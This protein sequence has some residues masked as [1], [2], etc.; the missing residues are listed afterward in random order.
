MTR[1]SDRAFLLLL[2]IAAAAVLA[3]ADSGLP[4]MEEDLDGIESVVGG[5]LGKKQREFDYFALS[6]QWPGTMCNGIKKCCTKNGCCRGADTP[7]VFTIHGLWTDYNDGSWPECCDGPSFDPNE[8]APLQS[9]LDRYWP[10]YSCSKTSNCHGGK[11]TFWGHEW[12]KHGTC[13]NPVIHDE[14]NYFLITLNLYFNY[15]VTKVLNEEGYVPSNSERYPLG[16]II[17]AIENAFHLTPAVECTKDSIKEIHLC[18]YK[19][20]KPRDCVLQT[21]KMVT[22]S[23][24]CPE[25]VSL[26]EI[27]SLENGNDVLESLEL[28]AAL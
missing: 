5:G 12:E 6:L 17:A 16:G 27:E 19:D 7:Q 14:Y 24:S 2:L 28:D 22:S 8:V 3:T 10:S 18:F 1:S 25:Y 15:N 26:P 20:F 23:A 9:A 13:A 21:N 11:G 4:V